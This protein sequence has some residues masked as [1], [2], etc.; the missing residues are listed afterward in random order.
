MNG[1]GWRR[2]GRENSAAWASRRTRSCS[3]IEVYE[4]FGLNTFQNMGLTMLGP[5]LQRYGTP[6][7]QQEYL[8]RILSGETYWCQGYSEPEAGSDLAALRTSAVREGP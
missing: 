6:A 4:T 2:R 7:Q 5:L 3:C 1:A 8:P